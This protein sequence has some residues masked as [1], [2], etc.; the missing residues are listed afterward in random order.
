[1]CPSRPV[2]SFDT[3]AYAR[4][5]RKEVICAVAGLP[6]ASR[7]YPINRPI[8]SVLLALLAVL[9]ASHGTPPAGAADPVQ[10]H[11]Q[12]EQQPAQQRVT[13]AIVRENNPDWIVRTLLSGALREVTAD[14]GG[15]FHETWDGLDED[16]LPAAPGRYGWKGV[17]M[18]AR[19]W[20]IDGKPHSFIAKLA[21]A[22]GLSFH[23]QPM[24]DAEPMR[25]QGVTTSPINDVYVLL[26]GEYIENGTNPLIIDPEAQG[27]KQFIA[28]MSSGGVGGVTAVAGD[29][30]F[31]Y[32]AVAGSGPSDFI[33]RS[34]AR[35][36]SKLPF[37][38]GKSSYLS[39]VWELPR[40]AGSPELKAEDY[41][42]TYDA[43]IRQIEQPRV[44][45]AVSLAAQRVEGPEGVRHLLYVPLLNLDKLVV[46]DGE[47]AQVL[48]RHAAAGHPQ[49]HR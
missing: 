32:T 23:P 21:A 28:G 33:L 49:R 44:S 39:D 22:P 18:P 2:D 46:L 43:I 9:A 36:G 19:V 8:R 1:M 25:F 3:P 48:A 13:L 17:A 47:T 34:D 38:A 10:I 5:V 6:R 27:A 45:S 26:A 12:L 30:D 24:E 37:G 20:P 41:F 11:Y 31:I 35:T 40:P 16:G 15:A 14:N 4:A 7:S 29:G 42:G